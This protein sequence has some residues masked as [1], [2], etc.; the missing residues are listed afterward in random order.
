MSAVEGLPLESDTGA[1]ATD[2]STQAGDMLL[3]RAQELVD[4]LGRHVAAA[5]ASKD[6]AEEDRRA[7][8]TALADVQSKVA[9]IKAVATQATAAQTKITDEQAVIATKSDHIQ[10]AQI[11]ADKVRGDLDRALTAATQQLTEV[12][13]EAE[14]AKAAADEASEQLTTARSAA[15]GIDTV[16]QEASRALE[17]AQEAADETKSL[18]AKASDVEEKIAAYEKR[19]SELNDAC[20]AQ[21]KTITGLLP[22]ATSA[23][24]AHAFDQRRQT[25]LNPSTRWQWVFV[26][27]VLALVILAA[28]GLWEVLR[29]PH[30]LTYQEVLL[31]W[32]AR[33]PIAAAL[34]WLALHASHEAALAK[35]LEE[36]YGYKAAIAASFQGFNDQMREIGSLA[37]ADAPL[38]VLC[39]DTLRTV[40]SP[41]GRIYDSHKLVV[42]PADELAGVA[43]SVLDAVK[44]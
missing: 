12:E 28:T 3:S 11:H 4:L 13:G 21:L 31:L 37:S 27:S 26:G 7:I 15:A 22:G 19:L 24:L 20:D 8:A 44:K 1:G 41:P 9:D 10:G 39:R 32:L 43:Q 38:S 2:K 30:A 5:A 6:S 14:K 16:A 17:S 29:D 33:M 35:R 42:S 34:V 18:A 23:G 36:D 40:G 25:F